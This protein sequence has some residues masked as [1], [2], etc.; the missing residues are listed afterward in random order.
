MPL[1]IEVGLGLCGIV[2]DGDTAPPPL[3]GHSPQFSTNV[4]CGQ[5]AGWTKMP[6]GMAV[7]LCPGDSV[8]DGDPARPRKKGTST[9]IPTQFLAHV[10]C[11]QTAGWMKTPVGI[12]VDLGLGHI[13]L[14][15]VPAPHERGT[16][17]PSFQPMSN[18]SIVATVAHLSYC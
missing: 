9:P 12:E 2:L 1:G 11:D 13:V 6:L 18:L 16:A 4:R 3:K 5:T 8:F 7:G 10:Y 17:A 14:N 15:R